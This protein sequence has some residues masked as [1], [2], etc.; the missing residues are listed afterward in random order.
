MIAKETGQ[1]DNIDSAIIRDKISNDR[2]ANSTEI[3]RSVVFSG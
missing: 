3:G 1:V 2:A